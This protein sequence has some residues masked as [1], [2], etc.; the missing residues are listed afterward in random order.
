TTPPPPVDNLS[1][2]FAPCALPATVR[3]KPGKGRP[4]LG[5]T[6][7]LRTTFGDW[8]GPRAP[9]AFGS[10]VSL[11]KRNDPFSGQSTA[12]PPRSPR[13]AH[14]VPKS[15]RHSRFQDIKSFGALTPRH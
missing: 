12:S 3:E 9:S 2:Q 6:R 1:L 13:P 10:H 4:A 7:F 8:Q 11:L 5:K 15:N 14:Q